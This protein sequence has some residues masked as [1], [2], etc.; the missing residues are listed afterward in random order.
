[1]KRKRSPIQ[2]ID[3]SATNPKRSIDEIF[4]LRD[5]IIAGAR[6]KVDPDGTGCDAQMSFAGGWGWDWGERLL[7]FATAFTTRMEF[8]VVAGGGAIAA[9]HMY[10]SVAGERYATITLAVSGLF[11]AWVAIFGI[12][13][14]FRSR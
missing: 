9:G 12:V 4:E 6:R 13:A 2:A 1:M 7:A 10:G 3:P 14:Q 5:A 8:A 11:A